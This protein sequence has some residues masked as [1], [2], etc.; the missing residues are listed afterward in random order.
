MGLYNV[1]HEV[2]FIQYKYLHKLTNKTMKIHAILNIPRYS[3]EIFLAD[4]TKIR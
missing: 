1:G 3:H 2:R 4:D